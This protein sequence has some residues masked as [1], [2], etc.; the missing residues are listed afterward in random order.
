MWWI[1]PRP[2]A[3]GHTQ[4]VLRA[5][6]PIR[7]RRGQ[8]LLELLVAVAIIVILMTMLLVALA[9]VYRAVMALKGE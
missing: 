5:F 8:T 9:K 3:P 4:P 1:C 6:H 2:G 7:N